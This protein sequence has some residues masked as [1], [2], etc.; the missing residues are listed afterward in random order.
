MPTGP[1]DVVDVQRTSI[2]IRWKPPQDDGGSPVMF[3]Q[4]EKKTPKSLI[5]SRV[6]KVEAGTLEVCCTNLYEKNE[7]LFRVIAENMLGQSQ[8]LETETATT[9]K[10]PFS[11]YYFYQNSLLRL[12]YVSL[13]LIF[14]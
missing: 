7:Y 6:E 9:A 4:V 1:I 14:N 11:E 5:W 3:Y 12:L 2:S 13:I 8:P 10:S